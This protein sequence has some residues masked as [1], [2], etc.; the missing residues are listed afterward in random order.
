V[1]VQRSIFNPALIHSS[2]KLGGLTGGSS[3]PEELSD[4]LPP[5]PQEDKKMQINNSFN[6]IP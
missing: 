3:M 4:S 5:P 2:E 6:F 1:N